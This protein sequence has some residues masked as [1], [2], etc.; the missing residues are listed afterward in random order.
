M[1]EAEAIAHIKE[2][3]ASEAGFIARL[4]HTGYF[5]RDALERTRDALDTLTEVWKGRDAIPK[6]VALSLVDILS[7]LHEVAESNP[8][9]EDEIEDM[10]DDLRMRLD[11]LFNDQSSRMSEADARA[12]VQAELSGRHSMILVLHQRGGLNESAV[13]EVQ[14]ALEV[15]QDA[16]AMRTE[17][18]RSTVGP[19]LDAR[20]AILEN[21]GWYPAE[22]QTKLKLIADDLRDRVRRCLS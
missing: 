6:D 4:R 5:D 19:M 21:A 11:R 15:L 14:E 3:F 22:F 17:V 9:L 1:T 8:S 20:N 7:R 2:Q 18:P 12:V 10:A 13:K 16:W